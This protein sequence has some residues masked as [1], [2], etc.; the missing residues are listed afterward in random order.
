MVPTCS[1]DCETAFGRYNHIVAYS[2]TR[3]STVATGTCGPTTSKENPDKN[4]GDEPWPGQLS[5]SMM[6]IHIVE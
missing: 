4:K 2:T 5:V 6:R 3:T 1:G